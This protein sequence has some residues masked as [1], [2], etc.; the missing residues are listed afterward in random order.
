[1][2]APLYGQRHLGV[3]LQHEGGAG[4]V[5]ELPEVGPA[6]WLEVPVMDGVWE[7][8]AGGDFQDHVTGQ[9][10]ARGE[11]GEEGLSMCR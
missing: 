10:L 8:E 3:V 6:A 1:M 9:H 7:G 11:A 5:G 4:G 2:P